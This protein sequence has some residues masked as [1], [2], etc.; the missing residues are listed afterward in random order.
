MDPFGNVTKIS[1]HQFTLGMRTCYSCGDENRIL[2]RSGN[3]F[4]IKEISQIS[5]LEEESDEKFLILSDLNV[6]EISVNSDIIYY[7]AEDVFG[8]PVIGTWNLTTG[9]GGLIS[10]EEEFDEVKAI[11]TQS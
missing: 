8:N 2:F 11:I 1:D 7:L 3:Y 5:V 4:V 9:S 10:S 6:I